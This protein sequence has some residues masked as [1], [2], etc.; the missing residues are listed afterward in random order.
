MNPAA[1]EERTITIRGKEYQFRYLS[2]RDIAAAI[3]I[4]KARL[5][6]DAFVEVAA[7]LFASVRGSDGTLPLRETLEGI[8]TVCCMCSELAEYLIAASVANADFKAEELPLA[9]QL[10]ALRTIVEYNDPA[11]T[12]GEIRRFFGGAGALVVRALADGSAG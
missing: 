11:T 3:G 6:F 8:E 7:K 5:G 2:M 9:V 4:V 12:V 1:P 10:A